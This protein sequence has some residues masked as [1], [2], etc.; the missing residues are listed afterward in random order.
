MIPLKSDYRPWP[1]YPTVQPRLQPTAQNWVFI[2]WNLGT[3]HLFS[4]L[5]LMTFSASRIRRSWVR[6]MLRE[7]IGVW[8]EDSIYWVKK[9]PSFDEKSALTVYEKPCFFSFV[10]C[11]RKRK[12]WP[13]TESFFVKRE[14]FLI[15]SPLKIGGIFTFLFSQ[16]CE[17]R[18]KRVKKFFQYTTCV[19]EV[20]S[21]RLI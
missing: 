21:L 13:R 2:L 9:S 19:Y 20:V 3:R 5:W 1:F 6:K 15:K 8:E 11:V 17:L 14:S 16:L 7:R 4:Y 10:S 18:R 12:L